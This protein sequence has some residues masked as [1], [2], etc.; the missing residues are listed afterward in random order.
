MADKKA[1]E[2]ARTISD[3]LTC[4]GSDRINDLVAVLLIDHR[5]LQQSFSRLCCKWFEGLAEA[6]HGFDLRNEASFKLAQA[7]IQSI[8]PGDRCLPL[9]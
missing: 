3:Y 5:T 4:Y 6:P 2:V 8:P 7:F 9:I 1:E